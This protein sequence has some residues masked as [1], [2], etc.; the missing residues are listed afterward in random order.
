MSEKN[1]YFFSDILQFF[2]TCEYIVCLLNITA[3]IK[4]YK[5]RKI[6]KFKKYIYWKCMSLTRNKKSKAIVI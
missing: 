2:F 1:L 4:E 3:N 5:N 6:Y